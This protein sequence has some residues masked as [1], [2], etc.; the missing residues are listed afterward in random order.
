MKCYFVVLRTCHL[1]LLLY[2]AHVKRSQDEPTG[3]W[4]KTPY[5]N[6]IRYVPSRTYFAR[7]RIQGE[8]IVRSLKTDSIAVAKLR[9]ADLEEDERQAAEHRDVVATGKILKS[10]ADGFCS[11]A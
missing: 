7:I 2:T 11:M 9:L 3:P 5:A 10:L 6:L 1:I 8:L 4:Q